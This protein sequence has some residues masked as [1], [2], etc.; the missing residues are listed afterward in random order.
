MGEANIL[1]IIGLEKGDKLLRLDLVGTSIDSMDQE[2]A[3][4]VVL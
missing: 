4:R 3:L 2:I 1:S